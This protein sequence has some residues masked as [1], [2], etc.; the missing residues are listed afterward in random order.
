MAATMPRSVVRSEVSIHEVRIYG[1]FKNNPGKWFTN[2][3]ISAALGMAARTV[4][5]HTLRFV[6]F[7]I[8]EQADVFP[9]HRFRFCDKV[10]GSAAVHIERLNNAAAAFEL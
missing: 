2:K 3:T 1:L 5:Q 4:R 6:K 7:K 9:A 8:I 10:A